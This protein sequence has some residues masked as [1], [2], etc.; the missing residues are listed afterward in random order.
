MYNRN[1][2]QKLEE[3]IMKSWGIVDELDTLIKY[4]GDDPFFIG[5]NP[6]HQDKL[7]N[8][9]I[10]VKEMSDVKFQLMWS[11]FEHTLEEYYKYKGSRDTE[12]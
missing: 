2:I 10:G 7:I 8:I 11:T 3:D 6:E 12:E 5:M 9:L 1:T 4:V